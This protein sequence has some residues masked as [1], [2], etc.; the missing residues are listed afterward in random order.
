M[1]PERDLDYKLVDVLNALL[2]TGV[3]LNADVVIT[4]SGVPLIGIKLRAALAGMAT[5]LDY[6]LM[7]AWDES[8]RKYYAEEIEKRKEKMKSINIEKKKTDAL[9]ANPQPKTQQVLF[10]SEGLIQKE[11]I[12]YLSSASDVISETWLPGTM[13]VTDQRVYWTYHLDGRVLFDVPVDSIIDVETDE[14]RDHII[15]NPIKRKN[16]IFK[17]VCKS[18]GGEIREL[19]SGKEE[20]IKRIK[21]AIENVKN[22]L[23]NYV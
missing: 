21:S 8:V 12:W 7:E 20:R 19:F 17:L 10:K 22:N 16:R 6:G 4:V 5:M 15:F 11:K 13:C 18:G 14:T 1:K 2:D 23:L 9:R 3:I